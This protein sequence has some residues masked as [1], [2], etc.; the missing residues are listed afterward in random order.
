MS[1]T[2]ALIHWRLRHD[3]GQLFVIFGLVAPLLRFHHRH[4]QRL[5]GVRVLVD[6]GR[7]HA[8]RLLGMLVPQLTGGDGGVADALVDELQVPRLADAEAVHG[9]DLH[10]RHHLGRR[11]RDG[12]DV[13]VGIDAAGGEPVADPKVVGAA[14]ERVR[15]LHGLARRLLLV[16]R[17][18]ERL[19]VEPDP[20]IGVFLGDRDA[21][22]VEIEPRQDVHRRRHVV[23]RHLPRA[24]QVGHRRE[25]MGAIDAVA[26]GAEHEVVAGRAPGGL[27][28]HLD[29]GHAVLG[30]EALVLGDEQR[31]GIGE[32]DEAEIGLGHLRAGGLR[33]MH[34]GGKFRLQGAEQRGGAGRGLQKRAAAEAAAPDRWCVSGGGHLCWSSSRRCR[35]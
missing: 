32:R 13:L 27:L 7:A 34:A 21:L 15:R 23:L 33:D 11:H 30:E 24:D 12:L 18:L 26:L 20:Q 19:G 1:A 10:V 29:A 8:E 3:G 2:G 25:D 4:Q 14:R 28:L 6:P 31:A 17:L 5:G 16:E 35:C 9:A 22:A